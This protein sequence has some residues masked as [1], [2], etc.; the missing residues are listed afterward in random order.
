MPVE[1]W[2]VQRSGRSLINP[3]SG[4]PSPRS[5]VTAEAIGLAEQVQE[6]GQEHSRVHRCGE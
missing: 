1:D 4:S 5:D 6:Q 3:H 2:D